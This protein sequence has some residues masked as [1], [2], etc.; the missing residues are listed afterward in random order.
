MLY[1]ENIHFFNSNRWDIL[2][3]EKTESEYEN[4]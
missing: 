3:Q 4:G 1:I 2:T